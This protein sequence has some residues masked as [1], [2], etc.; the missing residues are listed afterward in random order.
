M[1]SLLEHNGILP[2]RDDALARF[3]RWLKQKLEAI[4]ETAVR[5]P[6]EQFATWHH[7]RRLRG[8]STPGQYSEAGIRYAKQDITEAIKFLA[9][10]H[11]AHRR[12]AATC[13]QQDVDEW[14]A[15]GPTTRS[16]VRNFFAWAKK[17]R[18]NASVRITH[19]Q[20]R[21]SG[22]LTQEQR[23]AWTK[24]LL[25]GEPD[26]LAYR[27]A[28]ILLLLYAQPL[29]R[30]AAL[31]TTA[32]ICADGD[33]RIMLGQEPIPLPQLFADMLHRHLAEPPGC[34]GDWLSARGYSRACCPAVISL[35]R[36]SRRDCAAWASTCSEHATPRC[37]HW[38]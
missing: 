3:E 19:Q 26:T 24:E 30:I 31:Q 21:P 5:T 12:T 10:L 28:G 25:R 36:A 23:L 16:N 35:R 8:T 17:A 13:L 37:R 27:V 4:T 32:V 7:L 34:G 6:V 15:S 20:L 33:T 38:L 18:L 9:W 22:A 14:L 2:A 1:R 11:S 29:T